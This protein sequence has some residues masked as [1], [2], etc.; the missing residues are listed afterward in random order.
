[1]TGGAGDLHYNNC[2]KYLNFSFSW[3]VFPI[4][5]F[6]LGL[7]LFSESLPRHNGLRRCFVY[8]VRTKQVI[9]RRSAKGNKTFLNHVPEKSQ[10]QGSVGRN[11][12]HKIVI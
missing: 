11:K 6:E 2:M 3:A 5:D 9:L 8:L 7:F 1:M 12:K 10:A 4:W